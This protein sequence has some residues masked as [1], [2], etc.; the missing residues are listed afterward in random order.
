[1][2]IIKNQQWILPFNF[3]NYHK[4]IKMKYKITQTALNVAEEI[5]DNLSTSIVKELSLFPFYILDV[6]FISP[7]VSK[8]P[9]STKL[10]FIINLCS[11]Y[12]SL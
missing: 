7:T 6:S 12:N 9:V 1:M 10:Y 2:L 4:R 11:S 8:S 3:H 5:G